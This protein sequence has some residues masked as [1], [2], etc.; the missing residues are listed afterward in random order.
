MTACGPRESTL[1]VSGFSGYVLS[2]VLPTLCTPQAFPPLQAS[3][4][5]LESI[6]PCA[7]MLMFCFLL[8]ASSFVS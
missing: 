6:P 2:P 1:V 8:E 7:R 3:T 5:C 4:P